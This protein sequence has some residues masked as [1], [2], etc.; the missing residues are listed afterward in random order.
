MTAAI[1]DPNSLTERLVASEL[2]SAIPGTRHGITSRVE[3]MGGAHGNVAYSPPRDQGDAWAMRQAWCRALDLDAEA[4]VTAG[5]IHGAGTL[6]ATVSDG[7]LGARPGSGRLGLGDALLTRE[8]GPVLMTLHADCLPILLVDPDLPA[9]AAVHAGWRGTIAGVA[10]ATVSAMTAA[11]GSDPSRLIA[12]LG[13]A[14]CRDCYEVG[15]EVTDAWAAVA[16]GLASRAAITRSGARRFDLR[17]A[18]RILMLDA[19]LSSAHIESSDDCTRCGAG[20]WFSHRGQGPE[21]G[22]FGAFIAITAPE[23]DA[24]QEHPLV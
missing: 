20:A 10:P 17:E 21:T 13:P 24:K 5:Q 9:V 12:F 11:F 2:L 8:P 19:G 14:I 1:A 18:N 16:G 23:R 15:S 3:G 4:I 6:V 22:R 7:G